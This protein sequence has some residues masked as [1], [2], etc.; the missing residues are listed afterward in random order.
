MAKQSARRLSPAEELERLEKRREQ[1]RAELRSDAEAKLKESVANFN[2]LD[3]GVS[4]GLHQIIAGGRGKTASKKG[5]R[6]VNAER[7]C[8]ICGFR[9]VPPHDGR[10]HRAQKQKRPFTASEL[11]AIGMKKA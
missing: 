8:P 5:A 3:L 10:T 6:T 9:T 11:S 4:Y 2:K 7:A 1:L